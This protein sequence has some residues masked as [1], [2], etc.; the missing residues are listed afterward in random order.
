DTSPPQI[1]C[2]DDVEAVADVNSATQANVT[3]V[4]PLTYD[5]SGLVPSLTASP[6]VSPPSLFPIGA[7]DVTYVARDANGNQQEC[8]FTVKVKDTQPPRV[9]RCPRAV[10]VVSQEAEATVTWEEPQFSDNSQEELRITSTR[11]PGGKFKQGI[12]DVIYQAS[13]SAGNV[14]SCNIQ[15][16][17]LGT[18]ATQQQQQQQQ[19]RRP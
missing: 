6:A 17:V 4:P 13:D 5:N 10:T 15:V 18:M 12:T 19:Q 9:D 8:S 14:A 7:T 3:W 11:R 1:F 2:P 16:H